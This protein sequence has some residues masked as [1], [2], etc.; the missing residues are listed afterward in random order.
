MISACVIKSSNYDDNNI[1]IK[2]IDKQKVLEEGQRPLTFSL[3]AVIV[4]N[5]HRW[6]ER[7]ALI[8]YGLFVQRQFSL[9]FTR[10]DEKRLEDL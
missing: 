8:W 6:K 10:N 5:F 9:S 4:V 1:I 2:I 3:K 7:Y